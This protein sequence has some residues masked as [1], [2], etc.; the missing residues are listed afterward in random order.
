MKTKEYLAFPRAHNDLKT[1]RQTKEY[2]SFAH[3]HNDL[4]SML[5]IVSDYC[6]LIS[7]NAQGITAESVAEAHKE[8]MSLINELHKNNE[9]PVNL[10]QAFYMALKSI[11]IDKDNSEFSKTNFNYW[12]TSFPDICTMV[13]LKPRQPEINFEDWVQ[14]LG[15]DKMKDRVAELKATV[16][17]CNDVG[18]DAETVLDCASTKGSEVE[19]DGEEEN[20][21]P[22]WRKLVARALNEGAYKGL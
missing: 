19:S 6:S 10:N 16:L 7:E 13:V 5:Q 11:V 2:L 4:E 20:A 21:S 3:E 1:M 9:V 15:N 17:E 12:V 18:S 14:K 8:V 22:A